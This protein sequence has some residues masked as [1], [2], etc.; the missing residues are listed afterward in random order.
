MH[1]RARCR[2][3]QDEVVLPAD[4]AR[5]ARLGFPRDADPDR[6]RVQRTITQAARSGEP[7]WLLLR[8]GPHEWQVPAWHALREPPQ[9][10]ERFESG[11]AADSDSR[12]RTVGPRLE[13]LSVDDGC[14]KLAV[15]GLQ[16]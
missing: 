11:G 13:D 14:D 4:A 8:A 9:L 5:R 7:Q 15:A 16:S 1:R 3:R 2:Y 6:S 10:V 12:Q